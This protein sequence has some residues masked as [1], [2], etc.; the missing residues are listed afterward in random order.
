M[1]PGRGVDGGQLSPRL[2]AYLTNICS[3][4]SAK[5]GRFSCQARRCHGSR[6]DLKRLPLP[7]RADEGAVD[8]VPGCLAA[9]A[10]E[11]V[12]RFLGRGGHAIIGYTFTGSV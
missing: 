2:F 9:V 11:Y 7:G 6:A 3:I 8:D 5:G 12:G 4:K 10:V 1:Q